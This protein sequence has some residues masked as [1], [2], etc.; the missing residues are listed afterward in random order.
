[1]IRHKLPQYVQ[2]FPDRHGKQRLYFRRP[3]YPRSPLPGPLFSE[4]FFIAYHK[5][6]AGVAEPTEGAGAAKTIKGSINDLIARYYQS[7]GFTSKAAATQRNYKS[8]LEP[9]RAE[10]GDKGVAT[11]KTAHIDAILGDVAKRSTSAAHNLRKRL[12]LIFRLAVKWEFRTDNPLLLADRVKH[13]TKGY[14]TWEEED[15]A[16]F[17]EHWKI[18]TTQRLAFEILLNTGLRV[19][20]AVRL[21]PQHLKGGFHTIV[22]QKTKK[23]VNIPMHPDLRPVLAAIEDKHLTYLATRQGK[24]RSSKAFTNYVIDAAKDAGLP[25][26]RSAHGLRKAICVRLAEVGCDPYEIMAITGHQNLAEVMTY[27][28]GVNTKKKAQGAMDKLSTMAG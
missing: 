22:T 18:G 2:A 6:L 14:E 16:K 10:H 17:R 1:M 7:A 25:P 23:Q 4:A 15:I 8:V 12:L 28:A 19:S 13:D 27:I 21:G 24:S 5:A 3:G 9:F 20:D 26:H 11:I